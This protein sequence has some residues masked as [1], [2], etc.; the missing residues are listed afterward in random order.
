MEGCFL[1]VEC[2]YLC[3]LSKAP[4]R[5]LRVKATVEI[6]TKAIVFYEEGIRSTKEIGEIYSIFEN[7]VRRWAKVHAMVRTRRTDY[8]QKKTGSKWFSCSGALTR[9]KEN[10][11]S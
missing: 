3:P 5:C 4:I 6:R 11:S 7:T 10:D 2:Q 9:P 8:S 1:V